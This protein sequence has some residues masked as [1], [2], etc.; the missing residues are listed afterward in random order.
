MTPAVDALAVELRVRFHPFLASRRQKCGWETCDVQQECFIAAAEALRGFNP[1][2]GSLMARAYFI[3]YKRAA[4]AGFLP[5]GKD[6]EV[7]LAQ[8]AGG[9]DPCAILEALDE[10]QHLVDVGIVAAALL[11]DP[12]ATRVKRRHCAR[13]EGAARSYARGLQAEIF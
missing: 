8:V 7:A 9:D 1:A 5:V 10:I 3:L 6:F 12:P 2:R 4:A 13:L 11:P